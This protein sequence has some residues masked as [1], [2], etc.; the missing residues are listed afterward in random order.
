MKYD[1]RIHHTNNKNN[2]LNNNNNKNNSNNNSNEYLTDPL[3]GFL[4]LKFHYIN[5]V[6]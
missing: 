3:D 2:K 6:S 4:L 1:A 5:T